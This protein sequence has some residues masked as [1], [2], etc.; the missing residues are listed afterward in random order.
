MKRAIILAALLVLSAEAGGGFWTT[1]SLDPKTGEVF[2]GLPAPTPV[3]TGTLSRTTTSIPFI[4]IPSS[5]STP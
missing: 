1:Y 4:P 5:Q 3:S 2:G